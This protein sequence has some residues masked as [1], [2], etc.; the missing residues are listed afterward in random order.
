MTDLRECDDVWMDTT[1]TQNFLQ[2]WMVCTEVEMMWA[3]FSIVKLFLAAWE[4][5]VCQIYVYVPLTASCNLR[6]WWRV[7]VSFMWS[8]WANVWIHSLWQEVHG[9]MATLSMI[10]LFAFTLQYIDQSELI[11][12]TSI[13]LYRLLFRIYV[14]NSSNTQ[15]FCA[16]DHA[17][18][19]KYQSR[20]DLTIPSHCLSLFV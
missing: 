3:W 16:D 17:F 4:W 14:R 19:I 15:I 20:L 12:K 6:R 7:C 8:G 18:I 1:A 13:F 11:E 2:V 5:W 9:L 10:W